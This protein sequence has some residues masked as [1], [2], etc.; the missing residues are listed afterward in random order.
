MM[1]GGP[2]LQAPGRHRYP[3]ISTFISSHGNRPSRRL[4]AS[5]AGSGY[6]CRH[7]PRHRLSWHSASSSRASLHG[8][9]FPGRHRT[10]HRRSRNSSSASITSRDGSYFPGRHRTCHRRSRNSSSAFSAAK[11]GTNLARDYWSAIQIS[12]YSSKPSMATGRHSGRACRS[13][14]RQ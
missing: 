9:C 12:G 5:H 7:R 2:V 10:C 11:S 13:I 6:P 1:V 4:L 3:S 8:S 14:A